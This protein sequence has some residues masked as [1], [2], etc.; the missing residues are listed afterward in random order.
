MKGKGKGV[1]V[2]IMEIYPMKMERYNM[3]PFNTAIGL[4]D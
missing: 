2:P 1:V 4:N 3:R